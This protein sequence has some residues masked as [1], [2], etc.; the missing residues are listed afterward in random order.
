MSQDEINDTPVAEPAPAKPVLDG[1]AELEAASRAALDNMHRLRA[2]R[3]AREAAQPQAAKTTTARKKKAIGSTSR[4]TGASKK[5]EEAR[6]TAL[7]DWLA[8]QVDGGR[9]T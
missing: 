2:L 4:T 5:K 6:P 1:R 7:K 8:S 9:R 3:L